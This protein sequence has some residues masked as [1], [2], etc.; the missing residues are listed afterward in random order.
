MF[1]VRTQ[2]VEAI[3]RIKLVRHQL[4]VLFI[5]IVVQEVR[6]LALL[7][8]MEFIL[9]IILLVFGQEVDEFLSI[10]G[11]DVPLGV[12]VIRQVSLDAVF[13]AEEVEPEVGDNA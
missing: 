2:Y 12:V 10:P 6:F 4:L 11:S 3:P 5:P 8:G 7:G 13:L 9:V 1:H